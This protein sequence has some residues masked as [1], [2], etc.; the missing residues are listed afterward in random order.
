MIFLSKPSTL[1]HEVKNYRPISLLDTHGKVLDK[2]L[3]YRLTDHLTIHNIY[4]KRQHDFR[5]R[6]GSH[7]VLATLHET[8]YIHQIQRN[9]TDVILRDVFKAF[10]KV[11]HTELKFKLSQLDID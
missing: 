1:K 2:I 10:D 11:W 4:N 8:L 7:T 5:H 3:T 6:R 9:K